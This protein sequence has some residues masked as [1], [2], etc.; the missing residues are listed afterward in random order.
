MRKHLTTVAIV[1][2]LAAAPSAHAG[3]KC[4]TNKD[5]VRECGNS[6]PPE[7]AQ[8]ETETKDKGGLTIDKSERA[9]TLDELEAE[10]QQAKID[11]RLAE[12][13]RKRAA[14]NRVLLD[15]FSS[16]DDLVLTRDGQI[17]HLESQIRL[18][19]SHIEKL[20]KN[21][22]QMIDRAAEVERRG[23][24]ASDEMVANIA[25][26]R[27]QIVEN[28]DF[29]ASKRREQEDIRVRFDTD[30]ERFRELKGGGS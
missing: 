3:I 23:E 26:V 29:I 15:T 28:E 21:L 13:A 12:E 24:N 25:N 18:T 30:I 20:E 6:V 4:W 17:A 27:G 5:G 19:G 11:Q 1:I 9:K 8:Q 22:D 14:R 7:Y 2:V 16:E 10:R